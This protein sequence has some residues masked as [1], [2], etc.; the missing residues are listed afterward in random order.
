MS[1]HSGLI[2]GSPRPRRSQRFVYS[3]KEQMQVFYINLQRRQDRDKEFL[4]RNSASADCFRVDAV[5]GD[6]FHLDARRA[7]EVIAERLEAY[8]PRILASALSHKGLWERAV[9]SATAATIAEDDA[10]LN[11]RFSEKA[12][13]VIATL[14][15]NWDII[16]WGWNFDSILHCEVFPGLKQGVI[17]FDP[18]PLREKLDRFQDTHVDPLPLR[19]FSAFGLLCYSV[20]PKGAKL[21]SGLCFPLRNELIP[22]PGLGR[23]LKNFSLDVLMNKYYPL[24]KAYVSFPPLAWSENDKTTSSLFSSAG[25]KPEHAL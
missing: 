16:L 11:R 3:D 5:D 21:L 15:D 7:G 9:S 14:P 8:T 1:D 10:V 24:L 17:N 13:K 4:R 18:A 19:L 22:V 23:Q 2:L 20:T 25:T 12:A 6:S